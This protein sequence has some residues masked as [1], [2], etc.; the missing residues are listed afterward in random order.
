MSDSNA[1]RDAIERSKASGQIQAVSIDA[2]AD[3]LEDLL[4]VM[5]QT[6]WEMVETEDNKADVWGWSDATPEGEQDWRLCVQCV[7]CALTI[8]DECT[9]YRDGV[10]VQFLGWAGPNIDG[11][12]NDC[13]H[14][15]DYFD[16]NGRYRG[17]DQHGTY[18]VFAEA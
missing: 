7:A 2:T 11:S 9:V 6:D 10:P 1:I 14:V 5:L 15:A 4:L 13:Y 8:D 3:G 16:D 18:P 17:A 12:E